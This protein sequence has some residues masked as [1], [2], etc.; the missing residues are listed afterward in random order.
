M[1]RLHFA[2]RL[3]WLLGSVAV[4]TGTGALYLMGVANA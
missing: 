3:I 4:L 2:A 1:T